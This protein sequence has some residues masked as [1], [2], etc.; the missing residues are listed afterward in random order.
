MDDLTKRVLEGLKKAML[1]EKEG[2][3]FYLMAASSTSNEKGKRIF[4]QLAE[5]EV[6]HF[7]YLQAQ[8]A[9][10]AKTGKS[11]PNVKL[12][13]SLALSESHPIFAEDIKQRIGNAHYEMTALS[14][15]VQ[16]ET[17]AV[18]FYTHE[19][20]SVEDADLKKFY[21]DLAS[22]EKKHLASLLQQQKEL[23]DEY[24]DKGGFSPF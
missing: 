4:S 2:Q 16:L 12:T 24:W 21:L 15:G 9:S 18:N 10:F 22:W 8:Y 23:R 7:N 20:D 11:D 6:N 3:H 14:V 17:S 1:A 13:S 5:D 19:A